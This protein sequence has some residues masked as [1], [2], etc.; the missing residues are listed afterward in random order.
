MKTIKIIAL[1]FLT[2]ISLYSQEIGQTFLSIKDTGV[3]EFLTLHPEYDGRG[4]IIIILDTGVDIGVEGLTKTSTGEVKFIDVQDFTHQ[5]DVQLIEADVDK[6]DSKTI[7]KDDDE[8]YTVIASSSLPYTP[9]DN[10][11]FIG[12]FDEIRLMNSD[13][14]AGDLNGDGDMEDVYVIV[15]FETTEGSESFWVVFLDLNGNGDIS[16]DKPLRNYKEKQDAFSFDYPGDLPPLTIG[17]NILPEEKIVTFHFDDG[18]HG[19]HVAGIAGGNHIGGIDFNGIAPGAKMMS[20]KL[21]NNLYSGGCSVTESM[22][23]AYLYADKISKEAEVPVIINM[24]FGIGTELEGQADM[25]KFLESLT[26]ENP[27]LYICVGSGNEGPGISSVGLPS[28]S[29]A[30]F[31]SGAVL[32]KEVGADLYGATLNRDV[33]LY[34][35]S[36]GGEVRKPDVCSPGASTS[37]VPN[38]TGWDR[39]WGTSM[40][41]PYSAGVMSLLL[42]AASQEFPDVKIPSQLLYKAVRESATK[43]EG[44]SNLDQGHGYINAVNAY[45]LLKKYIEDGEINKF[46]T[47]SISSLSP[48]SPFERAPNLYLRNGSYLRDEDT[49]NFSI[50]RNGFQKSDKFYRSFYIESDSDLPTGQ[51][52]WLIPIQKKTYIRNDQSTFVNVKFDKSKMQEP[53]LYTG[54][55]TSYRD[56]KSGFPEFEMQATVI[57]PYRFGYE[58]NYGRIWNSEKVEQGLFKRYFIELPAGQT[59]MNIKLS[60]SNNNY[61]RVRYALYN[62]DGIG[63]DVSASLHTLDNKN[64]IEKNYFN[65]EPGVYE[66][67]VDGNFLAKGI[68][69]YDLSIKFY[70]INCLDNNVIDAN[71]NQI[72]VVNLFNAPSNYNLKGQFTGFEVHHDVTISGSEKFRMPFVL[73]KGEKSKEFKLEMN[74]I[75]YNKL[76]DLALL[77]YDTA[78]YVIESDALSYSNGRI[79]INNSSDADS[80]E[81]IFE[82][83]PGFAHETSSADINITEVT[84]F[85]AEYNISV[86]SEKKPGVNL[87]PSLPKQLQIYF[88]VPNEYFPESSQPVGKITFESAASKKAEYELPIKFKF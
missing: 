59:G 29:Y 48:N 32:T 45:N 58:N 62:P 3:E 78:G 74:K 43:L 55:L 67:V 56:D 77:I 81:Y 88:D 13:S 80:V 50:K 5:G 42:S 52:G 39:F 44:Y 21:G 84:N 23:K 66:V 33:I 65:L 20:M 87:Y 12:G 70:G 31:S 30:V 38:W 49:F 51:A 9:K 64:E 85:K 15:A 8:K 22:K 34:F 16:D 76:T 53:G 2:T 82:I 63:I 73:R 83:V 71:D 1:F 54:R 10:N 40:A 11:Y 26:E 72:K 4:T 41:A 35:S 28:S 24:S 27:Y 36:R 6:E 79:V 46:E 69:T 18:S 57:M 61:S 47:Y 25:E 75:D 14:G 19:T 37:T 17:L 68:S 86:M 7:F 60:A